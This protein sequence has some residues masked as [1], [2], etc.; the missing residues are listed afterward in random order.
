MKISR[1]QEEK[2]F[3][4][5]DG[6]LKGFEKESLE[7]LL[8]AS[9]E[10]KSRLDEL[11]ALDSELRFIQIEQPSK[12]FTHQ[13]MG[14]LDQY[15]IKSSRVSFRN[16]ILLLAGVLIAVGIGALL[17]GAGVFDGTSTIDL[18]QTVPVDKYIKNPL[19][20][21]NFNGKMI[22]NTIIVLNLALAFMV[23]DRAILKPWFE[24]RRLSV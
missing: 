21:F 15:P 16:G 11:R 20:T 19:P 12:N 17:L 10:L 8:K 18:N 22:V 23:L 3:E 13:V 7:Q 24:R 2:L 6:E 4:Y 14:K 9:P 5:I 1:E